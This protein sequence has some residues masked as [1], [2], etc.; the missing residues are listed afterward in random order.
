M[1]RCWDSESIEIFIVFCF[2]IT[3]T[4]PMDKDLSW[5]FIKV[6]LLFTE[7]HS[8]QKVSM[9]YVKI[10]WYYFSILGTINKILMKNYF[11]VVCAGQFKKISE[12]IKEGT[13]V[14][15]HKQLLFLKSQNV[16]HWK[17]ENKILEAQSNTYQQNFR[18]TSNTYQHNGWHNIWPTA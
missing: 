2:S 8:G 7:Q 18:G 9:A 4:Y 13:F 15:L 5:G 1:L 11:G 17:W 6:A 12:V 3:E 16:I 14:T 10:W